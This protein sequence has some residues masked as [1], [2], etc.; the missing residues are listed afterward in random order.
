MT[1]CVRQI[2]GKTV[3]LSE[4][5]SFDLFPVYFRLAEL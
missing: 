3:V 4:M 5:G 1:P 2:D